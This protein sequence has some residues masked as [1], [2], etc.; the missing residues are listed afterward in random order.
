MKKIAILSIDGGGIRGILP[1]TI[2]VSL[3]K[4]LQ[5]KMKNPAFKLGDAF[6]LIAGTS[7]GGILAC[8]YL[9]PGTDG[10]PNIPPKTHSIYISNTATIFFIEHCSNASSR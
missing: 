3:E 9:A 5:V 1:A 10:H 7:T 6:D 4:I 8:L 2:L